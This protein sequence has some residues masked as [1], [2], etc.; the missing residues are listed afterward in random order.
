MLLFPEEERIVKLCH[1]F[2]GIRDNGDK[3]QSSRPKQKGNLIS[4]PVTVIWDSEQLQLKD[5]GD[6]EVTSSWVALLSTYS[7]LR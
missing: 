5:N 6:L 7:S 1:G 4:F 2:G 3:S